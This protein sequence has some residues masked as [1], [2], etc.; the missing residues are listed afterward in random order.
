ME[1]PANRPVEKELMEQPSG[2]SVEQPGYRLAGKPIE[3]L[4]PLSAEELAEYHSLKV[5]I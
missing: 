5:R 3:Q 2:K 4:A 1:A